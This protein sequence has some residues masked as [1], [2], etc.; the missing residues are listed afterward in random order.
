M[1]RRGTYETKS[2][3]GGMFF[4]L[5]FYNEACKD[6]LNEEIPRGHRRWDGDESAWWVSDEYTDAAVEIIEDYFDEG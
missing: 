3:D 1:P 4:Y 2:T 6:R 5:S